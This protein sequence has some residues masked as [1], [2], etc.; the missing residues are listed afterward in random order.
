MVFTCITQ[1]P[2]LCLEH[3]MRNTVCC[4]LMSAPA[5]ADRILLINCLQALNGSFQKCLEK[6]GVYE[7]RQGFGWSWNRIWNVKNK[8]IL[9][10]L[11]PGWKTA[12]LHYIR[13]AYYKLAAENQVGR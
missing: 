2:N 13:P 3:Q 11:A 10:L 1:P 8:V 12:G 4:P 5:A 6:V 9:A 7:R